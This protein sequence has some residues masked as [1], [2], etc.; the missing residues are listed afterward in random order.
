VKAFGG[1]SDPMVDLTGK[2]AG[3]A[4]AVIL[5]AGACVSAYAAAFGSTIATSRL[6]L[7][8]GRDGLMTKRFADTNSRGAPSVAVLASA[9]LPAAAVVIWFLYGTPAVSIFSDFGTIGVLV[10]VGLVVSF[11]R[12]DAIRAVALELSETKDEP[13]NR[14]AV[15][16][17]E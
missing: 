2:Y 13:T 3:H 10:I 15:I 16:L 11:T 12:P 4:L 9:V 8:F 17:D 1:S 7:T 6:L 14:S 5:A